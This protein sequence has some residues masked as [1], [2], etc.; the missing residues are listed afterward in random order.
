MALEK[1]LIGQYCD[2]YLPA[3]D[4]VVMTVRSYAH[5]LNRNHCPCYVAAPQGPSGY[6]DTDEF[7]VLRHISLPIVKRPPYRMGLPLL[8][9][10][11][12]ESERKMRPTLIHAHSPFAAGRA[13]LR[14]ARLRKIPFVAT[15]H[16][17]YYDDILQVTGSELLAK[18]G[19]V[20]IVNFF[21]RADFVWAV[22]H[23]TAGTLREYGYNGEIDVMPNGSDELP[24]ADLCLA[25]QSVN[26][27]LGLSDDLPVMLFVGQHILQKNLRALIEAAA[28][29]ARNHPPFKLIMVGQGYAKEDLESLSQSLGLS[30]RVLFYGAEM[31]RT[32]L[33]E[34]YSRADLF[35]FP[36]EYDNA[37]I[38]VRE[39]AMTGCPSLMIHGSNA[40][41]G[42][43]DG[44][45]AFLCPN[46]PEDIAQTMAR[47]LENM[48]FCRLVGQRAKQTLATPW[49]DVVAQVYD[50]YTDIVTLHQ[51]K[52]A[53]KRR[54]R[55]AL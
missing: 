37:P 51:E 15:F 42:T 43:A 21:K 14:L 31:D 2:A 46:R 54:M 6:V 5:F 28:I 53:L 9:F 22:N 24:I 26:Q 7:E 41:E 52:L 17:K 16:S 10:E 12:A 32:R 36:S 47:A 1:M 13:G 38:V 4:G 44:D 29:Y 20:S 34:L 25:R 35:A 19:L 40:A 18:S 27:R 11:F 48:A 30:D 45:N 55:K 23:A 33:F 8:D 39:A 49:Q 50:R 3:M